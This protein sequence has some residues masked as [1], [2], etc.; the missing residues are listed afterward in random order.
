MLH[1]HQARIQFS[2]VSRSG[3]V[4]KNFVEIELNFWYNPCISVCRFGGI[5]DT[6][7][8]TD[9]KIGSVCSK[10][11]RCRNGNT[12]CT[13]SCCERYRSGK[14]LQG[15]ESEAMSTGLGITRDSASSGIFTSRLCWTMT[16]P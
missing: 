12:D 6:G 9:I 11:R 2:P 10:V 3:K 13:H 14:D 1:F 7:R 5:K 8:C 16:H 15:S 4:H